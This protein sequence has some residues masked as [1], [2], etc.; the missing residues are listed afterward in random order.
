MR[1]DG[2]RASP[3]ARSTG[4]TPRRATP[5][6]DLAATGGPGLGAKMG[7]RAFRPTGG[8]ARA[9]T[10]PTARSP[11]RPRRRNPP[12]SPASRRRPCR[13]RIPSAR[14]RRRY[15]A[16]TRSARPPSRAAG[17]NQRLT[18]VTSGGKWA[19][20]PR[21]PIRTALPST[22]A[23]VW[24]IAETARPS[25]VIAAPKDRNLPHPD[26][27]GDPPHQDAA[28]AGAEP[29]QRGRQRHHGAVGV[30]RSR[31]RLQPDDDDQRC[32]V[33]KR[34]D[35]ERDRRCHPGG[36]AFDAGRWW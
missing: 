6:P 7:R 26:P 28:E 21:K 14:P 8:G 1:R 11:L 18:Y 32:A 9:T 5:E 36:A 12:S 25:A 16:R 35:D 15:T 2:L 24:P 22:S 34:K 20:L 4:T 30:E 23:Q 27:V 19:L 13:A 29:D 3:S 33:G 17:S 31:D 10:A